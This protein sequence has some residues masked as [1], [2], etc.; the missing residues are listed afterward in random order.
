[1]PTHSLTI[2]LSEEAFSFVQQRLESGAYGS[3][4]EIIEDAIL[5]SDLS[6]EQFPLSSGQDEH[7]WLRDEVTAAFDEHEVDPQTVY[8]SAQVRTYLAEQ[9][10]KTDLPK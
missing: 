8:S 5:D 6:A 3:P 9:R 7:G 4:S 2:E 1:M 10:L